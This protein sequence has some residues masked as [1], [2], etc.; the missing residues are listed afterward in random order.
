MV[1]GSQILINIFT[2]VANMVQIMNKQSEWKNPLVF[3]TDSSLDKKDSFFCNA[4]KGE[5]VSH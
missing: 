2:S 1:K 4:K 3:L 5:S